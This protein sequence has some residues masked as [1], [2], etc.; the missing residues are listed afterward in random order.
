MTVYQV[1]DQET[2]AVQFNGV[3][4]A[5]A[6]L[7]AQRIEYLRQHWSRRFGGSYCPYDFVVRESEVCTTEQIYRVETP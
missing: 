3:P 4:F 2:D 7:A 1:F 5:T 6:A